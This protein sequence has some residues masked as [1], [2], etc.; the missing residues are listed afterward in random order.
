MS[1]LWYTRRLNVIRGP[2]PEGQVSRY[3]LLGRL[4][5][6]DELSRD[7]HTWQPLSEYPQLIPD[8]MKLDSTPANIE[9]LLLARMHED[10][11]QPGDRRDRQ[12]QPS[13]DIL[14]RR[15]GIERRQQESDIA[16]RHR[17]NKQQ[18][19]QPGRLKVGG[20]NLLPIMPALFFLSLLLIFAFFP[21]QPARQS[22]S[23]CNAIA[24]MGVNWDNCNFSYLDISGANLQNA[25]I[26]NARMDGSKL[27]GVRLVNSRLDYSN[28]NATNLA[29]AN[30]SQAT[31]IGASL[32]GSDLSYADLKGANL[33]Y[34]N[35]AGAQIQGTD[36]TGAIL[37]QAIWVDRRV[38]AS[39]SVGECR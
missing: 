27:A 17:H 3:I 35:L 33:S 18:L 16:F 11:R 29:T 10:E 23:D 21:R 28:M 8:V 39:G 34:A 32:S 38:C 20:P 22:T 6:T 4:R 5:E 30:L 31:M 2:Y 12:P 36:F 1:N 14:E 13:A 25:S 26:K 37:D 19:N 7:Q 15:L 24:D 9:S